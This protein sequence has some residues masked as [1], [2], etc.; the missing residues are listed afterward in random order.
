MGWEKQQSLFA[1]L[2]GLG[3]G[4]EVA[5]S[6]QTVLALAVLIG[7]VWLW[8]QRV[9]YALQA[10]G[11][12]TGA[13]LATPYVMDYDLVMLALVVAWLAMHG[14]EYGFLDWEKTTLA[15][16]WAVPLFA[17]VVGYVSYVP[18]GT[19]VMMWLFVVILRRAQHDL[20]AGNSEHLIDS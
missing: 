14:I 4:L 16:V 2:R 10:A 7:V 20:K 3:A 19:L 1:A 15:A 6:L 9:A 13:L 11:L 5:Y 12:V 8:R 18:L 17:R